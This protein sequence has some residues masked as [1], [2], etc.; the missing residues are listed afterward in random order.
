MSAFDDYLNA[1]QAQ[2]QAQ[3]FDSYLGDQQAPA[4]Q[5]APSAVPPVMRAPQVQPATAAT[6]FTTGA[7]DPAF[8]IGQHT[9]HLLPQGINDAIRGVNNW[10]SDKGILPDSLRIPSGGMDEF[11]NNREAN[12]QAQRQ[13]AQPRLSSLVTG[14]QPELPTDWWRLGG[15]LVGATPL[16]MAAPETA[17]MGLLGRIGVGAATGAANSLL[18][19]IVTDQNNSYGDQLKRNLAVGGLVGGAAVPVMSGIGAAIRGVTDPARR[20]LA[21]AGVTMTPGQ[22]LG[23]AWQRTEDKL[24][25]VPVLGDFIKNAQR[26]SIEDFNRATYGNALT[27]IGETLPGNVATGADAVGAVRDKI[28]SVYKSIEPKATFMADQ[29]FATDLAGIRNSLAQEAP[30]VLGQFDNIVQNQI[31]NKLTNGLMNGSQWGD[32]RSMLSRLAANQ[33]KGNADADKWALNGALSDLGN[34]VNSAVG[35]ASPSD[36]L[37]TLSKANA[38]YAQYKQLERAA[39]SVGASNAGNI[40]TPGQY[41]NAVR[42]GA[43]AFQKATNS[44]LN[45]DLANTAMNVLGSKYP[46]SGTAGRSMLAVGAAALGGHAVAPQAVAPAAAMLGLGSLPYTKLGQRLTQN[47]LLNRPAVAAP[48]GQ[49]VNTYGPTAGLLLAPSIARGQP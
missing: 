33:I 22:I 9:S 23:G 3:G 45:G 7:M 39:G 10:L 38:A 46:D 40:F 18:A 20:A 26:R 14:Q 24:S 17:G 8:A 44:G 5:A 25:S 31:T 41:A 1:G 30:G 27:P 29:N 32:T 15:N 6:S 49:F 11:V 2:G 19:P 28:G 12:Y 4:Q 42:N 34:A 21:D 13:A 36:V 35:R 37:P 43:T 16:A 47:M 48:I